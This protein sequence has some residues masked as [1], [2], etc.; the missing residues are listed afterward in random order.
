MC[1]V[2]ASKAAFRAVP[3]AR[4]AVQRKAFR[5]LRISAVASP[6][7]SAP[8]PEEQELS[9]LQVNIICTNI[10]SLSSRGVPNASL[11]ELESALKICLH[12]RACLLK[13]CTTMSG[14]VA[15][16]T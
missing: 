4:R 16:P 10:L 5:S 3:I 8:L 15:P 11:N 13:P 14:K 7:V 12:D 2:H 9:G 1:A 6:V